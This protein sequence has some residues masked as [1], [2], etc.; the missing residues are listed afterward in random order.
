[1]PE[2]REPVFLNLLPITFPNTLY[3]ADYVP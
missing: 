2:G 1:L 3:F